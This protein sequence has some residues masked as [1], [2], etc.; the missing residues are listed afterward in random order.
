[1]KDVTQC[2][3]ESC[4]L[5][6]PDFESF[7]GSNQTQKTLKQYFKPDGPSLNFDLLNNF[8]IDDVLDQLEIAYKKENFIHIPYQMRDFDKY[9]NE[10]DIIMKKTDRIV[11][12]KNLANINLTKYFQEGMRCFGVVF[13][14]DYSTGR[15]IHWFSLFG[16]FRKEPY[17]I[18]YFNSSGNLPLLEIS[19]WMK[20]TKM[21]L[22]KDL[23]TDVKDV[24]VSRIVHQ[25]DNHSCG[26]YSLYYILSRLENI[27][28][29]YFSKN[30]VPDE[31][32]HA[33]RKVFFRL[34]N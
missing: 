8:N 14:T 6:N 20:N 25:S 18:E 17:T 33:F 29:E 28:Y 5:K 2:K 22:S 32:M 27:P 12:E 24:I 10:D 3:S 23:N 16:D 4:I 11:K 13:N 1:M 34:G 19:T 26:V 21:E 15:G 9:K 30:R 31:L 7:I